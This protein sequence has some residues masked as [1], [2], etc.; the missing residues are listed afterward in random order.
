MKNLLRR[1]PAP[2]VWFVISI[3]AFTGG[4]LLFDFVVLPSLVHRGDARVPDLTSRP[5]GEAEHLAGSRGLLLRTRAEQFDPS[6]PKGCVLNQDPPPGVVA[7]RGSIVTVVVSLGE[8]KASIPPLR[9]QDFREVQLSLG[10]LGLEPG[11]IAR[12]YSDDVPANEALASDPGPDSP[13]PQDKP[14]N[15]LMSLGPEPRRYLVPNWVGQRVRDVAE[16]LT[17]AGLRHNLAGRDAALAG[18]VVSQS[19]A[20]GTLIRSGEQVQ[21]GVSRSAR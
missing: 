20:P 12:T 3:A 19:P 13:I 1:I 16:A 2:L 14:V 17:R 9:G 8:E 10:R 4:V 15:V 21:L 5:M 11:S 18:V 6:V 7:R